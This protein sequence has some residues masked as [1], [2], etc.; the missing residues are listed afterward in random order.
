VAKL[1]WPLKQVKFTFCYLEK[2]SKDLFLHATYVLFV[3]QNLYWI[4]KGKYSGRPKECSIVSQ[5]Y[6]FPPSI[7][8][9]SVLILEE[10][11]ICAYIPLRVCGYKDLAT[12]LTLKIGGQG[13]PNQNLTLTL[14]MWMWM[15]I[16][17]FKS[18]KSYQMEMIV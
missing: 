9:L 3:T 16:P 14:Y 4:N 12:W 1:R 11:S 15:Y 5:L 8:F 13:N 18:C 10:T 17:N 2:V 7:Y 6:G